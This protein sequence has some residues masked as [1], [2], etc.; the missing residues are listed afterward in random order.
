MK[1]MIA[2]AAVLAVTLELLPE[3]IDLVSLTL[4][5]AG[6]GSLI[7]LALAVAFGQDDAVYAKYGT[8]VGAYTGLALFLVLLTVARTQ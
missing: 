1:A 6:L 7:A 8:L 4:Q 5:F 2:G 3:R